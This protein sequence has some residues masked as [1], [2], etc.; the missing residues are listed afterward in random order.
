MAPRYLLD[1]NLIIRL[2]RQR[3]PATVARFAALQPGEAVMSAVVYGELCYGIAKGPDPAAA[4][5]VLTRLVEAVPVAPL[6][7]S[8]GEAY[9]RIRAE[10]E[11]R[12]AIIGANDLWIAAHA[13][14][15]GLVLVTGNGKEFTRVEGLIVEDWTA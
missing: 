13:L 15:A 10:L 4:R 1:T 8:A 2:R 7:A 3:P 9:G 6:P 12:G 14:A 11:A 5:E